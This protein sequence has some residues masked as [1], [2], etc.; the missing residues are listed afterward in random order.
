MFLEAEAKNI[1]Q[2]QDAIKGRET[3]R[4]VGRQLYIVYP[5][6]VGTSKFSHGVIEKKLGMRGTGRNWNTVLKLG[7]FD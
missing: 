2:L 5:D 4:A 6:G 1:T 3:F 7:Q